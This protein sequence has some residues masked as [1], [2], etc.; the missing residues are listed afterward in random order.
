MKPLVIQAQPTGDLPGDVA[1]QALTA[2]RSLKPS[3]ACSTITVA[4][5]SAG[6]EG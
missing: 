5:T 4:I 2:S 1:P 6:T 3:K